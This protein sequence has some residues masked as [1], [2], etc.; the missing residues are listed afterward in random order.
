[1]YCS[2]RPP[3]D[4]KYAT[5]NVDSD[6]KMTY[7]E[8][9]RTA[10]ISPSTVS[11]LISCKRSLSIDSAEKIAKFFGTDIEYWLGKQMRYNIK[12]EVNK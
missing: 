5:L 3:T 11:E 2:C 9:S 6:L 12:K 4:G 8:F 10:D 7:A 1:M